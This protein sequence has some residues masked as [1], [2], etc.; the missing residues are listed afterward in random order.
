M[1][2]AII[3]VDRA[4]LSK[5]DEYTAQYVSF[6]AGAYKV[7]SVLRDMG[8][9]VLVVPNCLNYTYKGIQQVIENNKSNLLWVGISSTFMSVEKGNNTNL[10]Q[11]TEEWNNSKALTMSIDSLI[12]KSDYTYD[13]E[14]VWKAKD[15]AKLG[16]FLEAKYN[17]PLVI[18]GG[19]S[20]LY[21]YHLQY[22]KPFNRNIHCVDGYA[23]SYIKE[24]T[25]QRLKNAELPI[26]VNNNH[27]NDNDFKINPI[28]WTDTDFVEKDDWLTVEVARGCAFNCAYCSYPR[29]G[30]FDSFRDPD[31]LRN[32]LIK[33]YEQFGVTKFFVVDDLYNDSKEKVRILYD[34]VWSKLPFEVEW[35]SSMRLDM[36]WADPDSAEIL[37]DSGCRFAQFGIET[38]HNVAGRRVGKGLGRDRILKTLEHINKV[39]K[40]DVLI[41]AGFIAGLPFEPIE[42]IKET[43]EWSLNTDLLFNASWQPLTISQ[44]TTNQPA[45]QIE[46]DTNKYQVEWIEKDNWRNSAG[47]TFKEVRDLVVELANSRSSSTKFKIHTRNYIDLRTLG[48]THERLADVHNNPITEEEIAKTQQLC[49][50]RVNGRINKILNLKS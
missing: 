40:N 28:T 18:G 27:Y 12:V 8:L 6:S 4:P 14:L 50:S 37:R 11:Y 49:S 9:D 32:E 7:A 44:P 31:S 3:F 26:I 39:W 19:W 13:F 42:S 20:Y 43:M 21:N 35:S 46:A 41:S 1:A 22:Y 36:L 48:M 10:E 30:R 25:E 2:H 24:F 16:C 38:L 15:M 29:R 45:N 47:V 34:K 17:V 5:K 33:N 23:E